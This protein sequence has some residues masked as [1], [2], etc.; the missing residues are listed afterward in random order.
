MT[1]D[2]FVIIASTICA[3]VSAALLARILLRQRR[4]RAALESETIATPTPTNSAEPI[5]TSILKPRAE[6]TFLTGIDGDDDR[7]ANPLP[8]VDP[9]TTPVADGQ[10]LFGPATPALAALL[11]ESAAKRDAVTRE[12][13]RAG[14]YHP[15]AYRNLSALRYVGIMVSL[16]LCGALLLLVPSRFELPVLAAAIV[17]PSLCWAL[18]WV[19]VRNR[20]A[21]RTSEIEVAMPDMLDMI[22]MCV[23]Q[24]LTVTEALRRT[25]RELSGVSPALAQ[26]LAIVHEQ[27]QFG[28]L[29]Q[30]LEN[31]RDRV[32]VPDVQ[33][34]TSL[35]IQTDRMGTSVSAALSEYSDNMRENLRQRSDVKAN[36]STFKLLFPTVFCLLPAVYLFLLGPAII[37]MSNFFDKGGLSEFRT[38]TS[39]FRIQSRD[40]PNRR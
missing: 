9:E 36:Q 27:A 37:E 17:L 11:P 16:I 21:D 19:Y 24:G 2:G 34:F 15:H 31:F 10:G 4:E 25:S 1:T 7:P 40:E 28:S 30:A 33:A 38:D 26:E 39:Q 12:L 22:N 13:R 20:A 14:Y 35:L 6:R 29:T 23:G 3:I 8:T 32:D 18:P 5:E